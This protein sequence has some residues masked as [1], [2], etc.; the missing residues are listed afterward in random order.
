MKKDRF[1]EQDL[2]F[3]GRFSRNV[4]ETLWFAYRQFKLRLFSL[5]IF[6]FLG[7]ALLLGNTNIIGFW[8]DS[9][10]Q[11]SDHII[12]RPIPSFFLGFSNFDYVYLLSGMTMIGFSLTWIFR[13]GFSVLSA[14]AVS[15]IYDET[16]YRTSRYPMSFFDSTPTGRVVTRFSSDYGNVFRLFG[17]PL[18]EFLSIIF[19]LIVMILLV[20]FASPYYL[21]AVIIISALNFGVFKFNQ[22]K[23]RAARRELSAS[24][25][26]SIAHF[27]ETTQGASTIRSFNKQK[28]FSNR[29]EKLDQYFQNQKV[30]VLK[31][32]LQF[33]LSM[34]FLTAVLLF[35]SG[36]LAVQLLKTGQLS[37]GS[38]GVAFGLIAL[39][40]NTV[41]MFFEWLAQFEEAMI[42]VE[43]LDQYIRRPIEL[44][45]RLPSGALFPTNHWQYLASEEKNSSTEVLV[46]EKSAEVNIENL[47]F[48]Y[49]ENL[50][51]VLKDIHFSIHAGE[52]LGI[53][54]RTGSGKSSLVQ[55]LLYLY[56]IEKGEITIH[57]LKPSL[58]P[59]DKGIALDS[60]RNL[61]GYITQESI[62][63]KGPL[64][65]NLDIQRKST[66]EEIFEAL[67]KVGLSEFAN[68]EGLEFRI[69]EKGK[70][71]SLGEKQLICVARCLLH[72]APV[73]IMDEATSSVDPKSEEILVKATEEFFADRTQI[74]I[75]HRLSTLQRCDR[76]LWL[77]DGMVYKIGTPS[78]ILPIFE[79]SNLSL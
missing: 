14:R 5:L 56:P 63:F 74:I 67:N 12:C 13:V 19:D 77:N 16:T 40:G 29:F 31:T 64:R 65:D 50:P 24:R 15:K 11:P 8:V 39:S 60:F 47:W 34:N 38:I 48:R 23:L 17:G 37:I 75:A 46:H 51:Y 25:S 27:A 44:G 41:Q 18:A 2:K 62:L 30:K 52:R 73:I 45:S 42:G 32:I 79:K 61:I 49:S 20:A 57:G 4:M 10:C 1:I 54:G 58:Q 22:G 53:I 72:E 26:P 3:T 6:G 70:N 78:E 55:A 9:F 33:S 59:H 36:A 7:R 76:I 35:V 68:K 43:R 28:T 21:P 69:E 71:L 66:D